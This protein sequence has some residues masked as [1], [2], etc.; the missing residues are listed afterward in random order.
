MEGASTY[1][2]TGSVI[3]QGKCDAPLNRPIA[4]INSMRSSSPI[5]RSGSARG[6]MTEG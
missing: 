6:N 1:R 2:S 3:R 5:K 4:K